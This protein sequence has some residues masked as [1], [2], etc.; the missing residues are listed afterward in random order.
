MNNKVRN[1]LRYAVMIIALVVFSYSSYKLASIY[2]GYKEGNDVYKNI[3]DDFF[4]P[5]I[6]QS[7]GGD[8]DNNSEDNNN[9][10]VI[11]GDGEGQEFVFDFESLKKLNKYAVGWISLDDGE[12]ISYPVLQCEDND[13]YLRRLITGKKNTA[14]SI[15]VDYRCEGGLDAKNTIIYGHNMRNLSMF[16]TLKNALTKDWYSNV[17]NRYILWQDING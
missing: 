16:G 14:G 5:N 1:L 9:N 11:E 4:V 10:I 6:D 12:Y 15:F 17:V 3:Q 8:E 13:K 7:E 2:I